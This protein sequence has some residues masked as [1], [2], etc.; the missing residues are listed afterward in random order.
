MI[1][2]TASYQGK[3]IKRIAYSDFQAFIIISTLAREG[4][5]EI[6]MRKEGE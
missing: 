2:I 6:G 4:A 3:R 5:M 1:I